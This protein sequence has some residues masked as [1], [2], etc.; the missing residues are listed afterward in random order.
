[1]ASLS[2]WCEFQDL[3]KTGAPH[4]LCGFQTSHLPFPCASPSLFA[5]NIIQ[6]FTHSFIYSFVHLFICLFF[7]SFVLSS[8]R[9]VRSD[10]RLGVEAEAG[11]APRT[12]RVAVY[13]ELTVH[14]LPFAPQTNVSCSAFQGFITSQALC[15]TRAY[16]QC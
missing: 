16:T 6:P 4:G 15:C 3:G 7:H 10:S 1:M 12:A 8:N 2:A 5:D 14:S 13:T 9:S 11:G